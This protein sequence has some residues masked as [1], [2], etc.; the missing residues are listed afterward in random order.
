MRV[1]MYQ[2][3]SRNRASASVCGKK[4]VP[5]SKQG[6]KVTNKIGISDSKSM[7]RYLETFLLR[8]RFFALTDRSVQVTP[9]ALGSGAR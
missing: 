1:P 8:S 7:N 4:D 3:I 2:K 5:Y 6:I 9:R